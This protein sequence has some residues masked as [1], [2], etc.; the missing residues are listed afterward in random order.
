VVSQRGLRVVRPNSC[1]GPNLSWKRVKKEPKGQTKILEPTSVIWDQISEILPQKGRPGNPG[2]GCT[3]SNTGSDVV[4]RRLWLRYNTVCA[5]RAP[6]NSG[7]GA[8]TQCLC[9]LD[10]W[11]FLFNTSYS[12]PEYGVVCFLL[13]DREPH[14]VHQEKLCSLLLLK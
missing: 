14:G 2:S 7:V 12:L 1:K 4:E 10:T 6:V 5:Y 8:H 11:R 3:Q 9:L 13:C